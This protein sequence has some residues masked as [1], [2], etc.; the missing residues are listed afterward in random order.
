MRDPKDE[1]ILAAALGGG[2]DYLVTGD[3]DLLIY[4]GDSR[5]GSLQIV[6]VHQFLAVLDRDS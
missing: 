2:A 3:A 6:T 5:L 4:R 1:P